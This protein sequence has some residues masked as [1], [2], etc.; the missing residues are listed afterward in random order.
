MPFARIVSLVLEPPVAY[1][2]SVVR[3]QSLLLTLLLNLPLLHT[4]LATTP[5]PLAQW[6]PLATL[7]AQATPAP[8]PERLVSATPV[9][10][11]LLSATPVPEQA[12]PVS[13]RF[14]CG[15]SRRRHPPFDTECP[16]TKY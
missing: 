14:L 8:E 16:Y 15:L 13:E 5:A 1:F 11:R 4:R 2:V 6:L 7:A 3:L 12:T 9:P 10:E